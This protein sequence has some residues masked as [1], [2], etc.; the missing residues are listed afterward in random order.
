MRLFGSV[1]GVIDENDRPMT[2]G[3]SFTM[4]FW[5][6]RGTLT[7]AA[8]ALGGLHVTAGAIGGLVVDS[9]GS[10]GRLTVEAGATK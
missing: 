3:T 7:T 8:S 10:A 5:A 9:V 2:F 4:P 6:P 1:D